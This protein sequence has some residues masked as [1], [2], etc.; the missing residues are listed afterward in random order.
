[1][2]FEVPFTLVS[3]MKLCSG[4][5]VDQVVTEVIEC[6]RSDTGFILSLSHHSP[7]HLCLV[8]EGQAC[9]RHLS[10]QRSP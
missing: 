5:T 3:L 8:Q 7:F 9:W 6:Q 1:M 10:H 4:C 2:V